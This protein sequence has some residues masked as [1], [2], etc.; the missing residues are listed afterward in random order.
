MP[1]NRPIKFEFIADVADYLR[2]VK[3]MSVSTEDIA[4]AFVAVSNSSD[5]LERKLA[6]AMRESER[7]VERLEKAVRDLPDASD[8]AADKMVRDFDRAG[9]EIAETGKETGSDLLGNLGEGL[10]SGDISDTLQ[11][12]L[13]EALGKVSGPGSAALAAAAGLALAIWN[14]FKAQSEK[15]KQELA[16]TFDITDL[17][18]GQIDKVAQLQEAFEDLGGGDMGAGISKARE[19]AIDLGLSMEDVGAVITGEI[20]PATTRTAAYLQEQLDILAE[21]REEQG[22]LTQEQGD[23]EVQ[24]QTLLDLHNQ[25]ANAIQ[26]NQDRAAAYQQALA[27]VQSEAINIAGAIGQIDVNQDGVIDNADTLALKTADT[28]YDGLVD[29]IEVT[30]AGLDDALEKARQLDAFQF[31]AKSL[32]VNYTYSTNAPKRN[33]AGQYWN[34]YTGKWINE[35]GGTVG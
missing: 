8:D 10:A 9:D 22:G 28:N 17:V 12:T 18:T 19:I 34:P 13:G 31:R 24:L 23:Q 29:S 2:D 30:K 6:R 33:T 11:D 21:Q 20:N 32:S 1:D 4:D 3:K 27:G 26:V 16:D 5:D 7:D 25:N 35:Q 14:V 15:Q